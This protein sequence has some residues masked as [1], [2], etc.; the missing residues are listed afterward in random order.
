MQ[1]LVVITPEERG[2]TTPESPPPQDR[3]SQSSTQAGI[4]RATALTED[5]IDRGAPWSARA[6]SR[7]VLGEAIIVA[8]LG[9]LFWLKPLGGA[10]TTLQLVGLILLGGALIT[11]FQ[12]WRHKILPRREVLAAF[13]SGS[14]VTVGLVVVVAAFFT[15]VTDEVSASLA[16]VIGIGFIIFGV[17]GIAAN[18]T[19]R[20]TNEPLPAA[21]LI[22]DAGMLVAGVVLTF[23]GTAGSGAVDS[24]FTLLGI[25]LIVAGI[26]LGA[27]A[28]LLYQRESY[29]FDR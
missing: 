20:S 25:L 7:V 23:S 1:S 27:Y 12:L 6:S 9:L 2:L 28:Y 29:G 21:S 24:I 18:F 22:A 14:G 10:S 16:V 26:A 13:R 15:D 11:A 5:L 4:G 19:G 8:I 3:P 17:A